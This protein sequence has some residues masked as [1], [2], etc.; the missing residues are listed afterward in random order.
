VIRALFFTGLLSSSVVHAQETDWA[1]VDDNMQTT[2]KVSTTA[3][4]AGFLGGIVGSIS[5]QPLLSMAS[6]IAT[7]GGAVSRTASSLRQRRSIE[8][9]GT[10]VSGTWGYTSWAMMG[11]NVGLT[12]AG[13]IYLSNQE[14]DKD[15]NLPPEAVGPSIGFLLGAFATGI[16][17]LVASSKQM[18]VNQRRRMQLGQSAF[19][20]TAPSFTMIWAPTVDQDGRP[21]LGLKGQF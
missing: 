10:D 8:E 19:D 4:W 2:F 5:G 13:S 1:R 12:V 17:G 6:N 11:T 7:A 9:R 16:G 15:G 3:L 18:R 14:L 20:D 21:G